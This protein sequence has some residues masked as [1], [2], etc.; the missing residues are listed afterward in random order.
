MTKKKKEE[1]QKV[2]LK[3]VYTNLL[4]ILKD[5]ETISKALKRLNSERGLS[6]MEER[7]RRW[8]AKKAGTTIE[9]GNQK[10][11]AELTSLADSL[12][13]LGRMEAYQLNPTKLRDLLTEL[14]KSNFTET[15]SDPNM[16]D[17]FG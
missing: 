4:N 5:D 13:S 12:I 9:D 16:L 8:A 15:N 7:K 6:A 1:I 17:M 14:D 3:S 2:N 11:V 10:C